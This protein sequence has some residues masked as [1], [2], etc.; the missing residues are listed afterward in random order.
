MWCECIHTYIHTCMHTYI[1]IHTYA[2][3]Y[4]YIYMYTRVCVCVCVVCVCVCVC[5]CVFVYACFEVDKEVRGLKGPRTA[6]GKKQT[7][8]N[9]HRHMMHISRLRLVFLTCVPNVFLTW[10]YWIEYLRLLLLICSYCGVEVTE[11][12]TNTQHPLCLGVWETWLRPRCHRLKACLY[13]Y[14]FVELSTYASSY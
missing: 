6:A 1:H 2:N 11:L 5:V 12:S 10:G 7:F 3:M 8:T 13:Q 14:A 4:N 9:S